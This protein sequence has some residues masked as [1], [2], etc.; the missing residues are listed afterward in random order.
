MKILAEGSWANGIAPRHPP[1]KKRA[2]TAHDTWWRVDLSLITAHEDVNEKKVTC[3]VY[4]A[5]DMS[6]KDLTTVEE[7]GCRRFRFKGD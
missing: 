2:R 3:E 5:A 4:A 1:T 7:D 6:C